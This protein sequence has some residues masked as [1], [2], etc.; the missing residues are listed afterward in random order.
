MTLPGRPGSKARD[1]GAATPPM[2][3]GEAHSAAVAGLLL[4]A[5]PLASTPGAVACRSCGRGI[6]VSPSWRGPAP[7]DLCAECYREAAP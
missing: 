3:P 2:M 1:S 4:A 6:W 5:S 7:R